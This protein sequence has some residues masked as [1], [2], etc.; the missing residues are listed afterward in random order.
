MRF[1]LAMVGIFVTLSVVWG[2]DF[3]YVGEPGYEWD[4][5]EPDYFSGEDTF[6]FKIKVAGQVQPQYVYLNLDANADGYFSR[7]EQ[8]PM[9]LVGRDD[10]GF[11]YQVKVHLTEPEGNRPM[12]YYFSAQ[13]GFETKTS[14]LQLGPFWRKN[15]SFTLI[16]D[17]LWNPGRLI[18]PLE[19]IVNS[20]N[21]KFMLVNTGDVPITFGLMIDRN[22]QTV[23]KPVDR[24]EHLGR[25]DTYILSA[26][27]TKRGHR[28]P[29]KEE[30]NQRDWEDVLLY[31]PRFA[32]GEVFGIDG[33]SAGEKLAP[34]DTAVLWFQF[35][36]PPGS[37]VETKNNK[38]SI[39]IKIFAV[40]E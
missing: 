4:G 23:W 30:F 11:V 12:G 35:I 33:Y 28:R 3:V 34:G 37:S 22:S 16:G 38:Q 10:E 15:V 17:T 18:M 14:G 2:W 19:V 27:F 29:K 13:V 6:V 31:S 7:S 36:A 21:S 5:V 40:G 1:L 20:E 8:F 9:K 24:Y 26:V 39:G 25:E 32:H